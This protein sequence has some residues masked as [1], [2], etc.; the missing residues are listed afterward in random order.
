MHVKDIPYRIRSYSYL[1]EDLAQ[2]FNIRIL[3]K[4]GAA[5]KPAIQCL[6]YCIFASGKHLHIL[7]TFFIR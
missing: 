5:L 7:A 3:D 4:V 2:K 6:A 1:T